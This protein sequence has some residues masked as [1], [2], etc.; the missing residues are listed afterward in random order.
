MTGDLIPPDH[1][2]VTPQTPHKKV[3]VKLFASVELRNVKRCASPA[4]DVGRDYQDPS[5]HH[6]GGVEDGVI[7]IGT[8]HNFG[9]FEGTHEFGS[10]TNI[11]T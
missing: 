10:Y 3:K 4:V 7:V 6:G 8:V 1:D 9:N 11:A 5:L 2:F